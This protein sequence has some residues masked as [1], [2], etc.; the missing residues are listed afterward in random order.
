MDDNEDVLNI[1]YWF[2]EDTESSMIFIFI[3]CT[4]AL[5]AFFYLLFLCFKRETEKVYVIL[6]G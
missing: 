6:Y 4:I 2:D 1:Y 3:S 5:V